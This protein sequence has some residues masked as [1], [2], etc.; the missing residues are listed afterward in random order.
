M[1]RKKKERIE[2]FMNPLGYLARAYEAGCMDLCLD[3]LSNIYAY[4]LRK[5]PSSSLRK[6]W[7]QE[8]GFNSKFHRKLRQYGLPVSR[9]LD[10]TIKEIGRDRCYHVRID[11]NSADGDVECCLAYSHGVAFPMDVRN[12]CIA[13]RGRQLEGK[14]P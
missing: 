8:L 7:K 12:D 9:F 2:I 5:P 14:F 3:V 1:K 4:L 13:K 11:T 10:F 6:A